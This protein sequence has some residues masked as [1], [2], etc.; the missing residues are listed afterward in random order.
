MDR[1][2]FLPGSPRSVGNGRSSAAGRCASAWLLPP[3]RDGPGADGPLHFQ[4]PRKS[5]LPMSDFLRRRQNVKSLK[6]RAERGGGNPWTSSWQ[7]LWRCS[8]SRL[9]VTTPERSAPTVGSLGQPI[10]TCPQPPMQPSSSPRSPPPTA[11]RP[12]RSSPRGRLHDPQH[13]R[14]GHQARRG[15]RAHHQA[16][17]LSR[18][19]PRGR[20]PGSCSRSRH[21]CRRSRGLPR[22]SW[23]DRSWSCRVEGKREGVRREWWR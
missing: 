5:M 12:P 23:P 7:R 3:H 16:S 10:P 14:P 4:T 21:S 1:E 15:V 17:R 6:R 8:A 2:R 13:G 9:T 18:R 11:A 20:D 19:I 22:P